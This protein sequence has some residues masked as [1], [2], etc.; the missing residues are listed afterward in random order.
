MIDDKLKVTFEKLVRKF[1]IFDESVL[2]LK[3]TKSYRIKMIEFEYYK[4]I[5]LE[6]HKFA[7]VASKF[8]DIRV[9]YT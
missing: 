4:Q 7:S 9:A 8:D 3:R 6:V 1:S 5:M 2:S